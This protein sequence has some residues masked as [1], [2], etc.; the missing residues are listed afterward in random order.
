[1]SGRSE[2]V[3]AAL[4]AGVVIHAAN[5]EIIDANQRARELLGIKDLE[6]RLA[7][8]PQWE[9]MEADGSP[10]KRERFPVV[11]VMAMGAPVHGLRMIVRPPTRPL[12]WFEVNAQPVTDASGTLTEIVVTFI[13][14]TSRIDA[15][16]ALA[17]SEQIQRTVL[18]NSG[19]GIVRLDRHLQID[20]VNQQVAS[21]LQVAASDLLGRTLADSCYPAPTGISWNQRVGRIIETGIPTSFEYHQEGALAH[22]WHEVTLTP[23][24]DDDGSVSHVIFTDRDITERKEAEAAAGARRA[25]IRQAERAA[26]VGT[27]SMDLASHSPVWSEELLLIHGLNPAGPPPDAAQL[28]QLYT[29]ESWRQLSVA[30]AHTEKT[31]RPFET[32]VELVRPDGTH[33]WL[34]VRG[35]LV[36]DAAG[37]IV[38]MH[39]VT[40]DISESKR[41]AAELH[42]LATHDPLTGLANRSEMFVELNRAVV[43]DSQAGRCTALLKL[44]LDHFK[45]I[46]ESVG[47]G[48]GDA[49]LSAAAARIVTVASVGALTARTGGDEFVV[50][51]NDLTDPSDALNEAQRLVV[52]FRRPFLLSGR[53]YFSTVSIGLAI[54]TP[55]RDAGDLFRDADTALHAAKSQGRDR[56]AAVNDELRVTVTTRVAIETELRRA[57]ERD[58]LALWYQPEV[59]LPTGRIT[60]VEALLRWHHPDGSVWTADRFI[61]VAEDTGLILSIGEWVLNQACWQ[62]AAWAELRPKDSPTV[63]INFSTLQLAEDG[64]LAEIDDVLAATGVDPTQ[65]CVEITET[66][67]LHETTIARVNLQGIHDRGIGVAIDD[68]GTGY[69]SLTYLHN[70]PV[71]VIKI[72]RSFLAGAADADHR[73]VAGI[74]ELAKALDMAVT[75][76]GV[77]YGEQATRLRHLGCNR[78]QG[79]LY[80]KAVPAAELTPMLHRCFPV[81]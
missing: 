1:M 20:Y 71:D 4:Q 80:S 63:R 15:E 77:E 14:I 25:Q 8:D 28:E 52:A 48:L 26:H 13:D 34:L 67:L 44:D 54:A 53:E 31:G 72:D 51:L 45:N 59:D 11:Q 49:L 65:L 32:E 55:D 74:I 60:A 38:G 61:D 46:N 36:A 42:M 37:K 24:V 64:L 18:D 27:W 23:Q 43:A 66:T 30:V 33:S 19:Q 40:A 5:S 10:M 3:F 57:L 9:F 81:S 29:P 73:L 2:A 12:A 6:G 41:A 58:Q 35:E 16:R 79:W 68:F 76:E 62:A 47:H 70:F 17:T 75:A 50:M 69:A 39:G 21:L 78:A 7:T 56:F 22:G